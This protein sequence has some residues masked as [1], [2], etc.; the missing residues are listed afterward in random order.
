MNLR[1]DKHW[2]Y[3][4]FSRAGDALGQRPWVASAGVQIDKTTESIKELRR[5]V[6]EYI[7]AKAPA[8][9]DELAHLKSKQIRAL[10][11]SYETASSVLG[12]L[13]AM[14]LFGRPDDYPQ[15][16]ANRIEALTLDQ[17]KKSAATLQPTA[18]TWVI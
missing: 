16:R 3:G 7:T 4:A 1:E 15:Q 2:S 5:E 13:S 17:L 11:G 18:L 14:Q 6:V 12:T 10:P 9:P 8:K